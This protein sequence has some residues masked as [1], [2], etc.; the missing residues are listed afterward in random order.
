[1]RKKLLKVG[2][3]FVA[4]GIGYLVG[5]YKPGP[6]QYYKMSES[7]I[8]T[9]YLRAYQDMKIIWPFNASAFPAIANQ[10][11]ETTRSPR[12]RGRPSH[13]NPNPIELRT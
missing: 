13:G 2:A 4:F 9:A 5:S 1:M 3:L 11:T 8:G 10:S 6:A 7:E 12:L